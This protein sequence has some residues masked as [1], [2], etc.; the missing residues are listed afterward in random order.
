MKLNP[1]SGFPERLPE[2]RIYEQEIIEKIKKIYESYAFVPIETRA[3]EYLS[4][5]ASKASDS[6]EIYSLKRAFAPEEEIEKDAF[7]LHFDLTVPFARYVAENLAK[8][9]FPFRRY[10]VQK[11]WRGERPQKGRFR[12]FYQFDID[13]IAREELPLSLE[14][15]VLEAYVKAWGVFDFL[16]YKIFFNNRKILLGFYEALGIS[17][18]KRKD[19]IKAVDKISKIYEDGVRE[20]LIALN[21]DSESINK[22]LEFSKGRFTHS[23]AIK[24]LKEKYLKELKI[25]SK[26]FTLGIEEMETIFSLLSDEVLSKIIVDFSLARG[27]DYYTGS[28]FEVKLEDRLEYGALG[29]GGSYE[30]L[31]G[32]FINKS[33]PGMGASIGITR[34]VSL[35]IDEGLVSLKKSLANILIAVYDEAQRKKCNKI[36]NKLRKLGYNTEV[37]YKSIKIGKQIEYA[38]KLGIPFI[39]FLDPNDN[40]TISIKNLKTKEQKVLDNLESLREI[41]K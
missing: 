24:Y 4:T 5:L 14:A 8:L 10:Q 17:E 26:L 12:E 38:D 1:I 40:K 22:I 25:T 19:V 16:N 20:E 21:I 23:D 37:F 30:N 35:I 39:L 31:C 32:D 3:I 18:D 28:I 34:I 27:L 15:E 11:V 41:C 9:N 33:L 13:V 36:A 2:E 29:A 7:S 6:K